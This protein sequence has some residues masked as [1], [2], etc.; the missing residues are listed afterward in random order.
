[1]LSH[2]EIIREAKPVRWDDDVL[3]VVYQTRGPCGGVFK[4]LNYHRNPH[5]PSD[6][7]RRI[8]HMLRGEGG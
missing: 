1:M 5:L 2:D 3:K 6:P 8:E 4:M 7:I